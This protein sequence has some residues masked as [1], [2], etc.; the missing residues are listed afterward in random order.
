[1]NIGT[2]YRITVAVKK[3]GVRV[4]E[5]FSAVITSTEPSARYPGATYFGYRPIGAP[6]RGSWGFGN[7]HPVPKPFGVQSVVDTG[8]QPYPESRWYP[9]PGNRGYDLMC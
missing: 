5:S 3:F 2:I 8:K 6:N 1:M 4:E 9:Q 7:L